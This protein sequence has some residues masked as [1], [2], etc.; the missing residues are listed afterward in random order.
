MVPTDPTDAKARTDVDPPRGGDGAGPDARSKVRTY[1][2]VL[3]ALAAALATS[4]AYRYGLEI[5]PRFVLGA[6]V[7][8]G[9][10]LLADAFP[11][12]VNERHEINAVDVVLLTS[13]AVLGPFWAA[14]AALPLAVLPAGARKDPLRAA[15]EAGCLTVE[16]YAA[17]LVLSLVSEPLLSGDPTGG[18]AAPVVY[19]TLLAGAAMVGA[20]HAANGVLLGVK[21]RMSLGEIWEELAEP[22]LLSHALNVLTAGLGVF[23]LLARGPAAAA[24]LVAGSVASQALV[25]RAREHARE[26]RALR[27][28]VGSLREALAAAGASFGAMIVEDLGHKDG[29]T[30]HHAAAVSVYAADIARELKLGGVREGRLRTA[31][32]LHNVGLFGLPE[33]ILAATGTLNS[34]AQARLAEHPA[35]G[36][37]MLRSVKGFEDVASW[38]RWH[39]ERPDGRGYPDKLRAP[40]IPVEAKILAVAQ[41]YAAMVLDRPHR[42]GVGPA[43]ARKRLAA[44]IDAQFDGVV[45]RAFLRILDTESEGYRSAD[46]HRFA[47]PGRPAPP[48]GVTEALEALGGDA[49]G[50]PPP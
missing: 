12:R 34:V 10:L 28:E 31:G 4:W 13:V 29:Y 16:V 21:Y 25:Y 18:P 40:W 27:A 1:V 23:A 39:H 5:G 41:A 22:Y 48:R 47:F 30:H 20:N 3:A 8:A 44:G 46:D 2:G 45:V 17:G 15:Y 24:L 14:V 6:A 32:L 50:P 11:V 7:S 42:P 43:E 26:S 19:G 33:E 49:A 36:E 9:L 35:R 37:R 38:V